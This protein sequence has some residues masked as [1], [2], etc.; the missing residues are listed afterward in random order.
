MCWPQAPLKKLS[1]CWP[2]VG[3]SVES[4]SSR[5]SP[6]WRTCSPAET[7]EMIQ[8]RVVQA[9]QIAGG[10]RILPAAEGGLGAE[11]LFQFLIGDDLQQRIV[12]QAVG[13]VGVFVSGDDLVNAL[14]QQHQRVVLHAI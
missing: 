12:A 9:H 3:S 4:M 6:R 5:I 14:P 1:C 8:Q 10:R 13:V 7:E 11:H 2:C